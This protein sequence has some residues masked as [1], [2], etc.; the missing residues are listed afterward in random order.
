VVET[1]GTVEETEPAD[2]ALYDRIS[3]EVGD[4]ILGTARNLALIGRNQYTSVQEETMTTQNVT[5]LALSGGSF[6]AY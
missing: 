3:A 6:S 1:V 5:I 4:E 2:M